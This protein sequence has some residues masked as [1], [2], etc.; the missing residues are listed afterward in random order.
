MLH[1]VHETLGDHLAYSMTVGG[2]HWDAPATELGDLPGPEPVF[3][4]APSQIAKRTHDWGRDE[5]D[6][7]VGEAWARYADWADGWVAFVR[8]DSADAVERA[9]LELLDGGSDPRTGYICSM[10]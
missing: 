8:A 5:L 1:A 3:F 4:F 9:Y 7:R 6:A 2:T 10:P